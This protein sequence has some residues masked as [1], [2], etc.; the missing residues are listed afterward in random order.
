MKDRTEKD[1]SSSEEGDDDE[2]DEDEARDVVSAVHETSSGGSDEDQ[3]VEAEPD[4]ED[5]ECEGRAA[6]LGVG[7]HDLQPQASDDVA[8]DEEVCEEVAEAEDGGEQRDHKKDDDDDDAVFATFVTACSLDQDDDESVAASG[9]GETSTWS[10]FVAVCEGSDV[11]SDITSQDEDVSEH[12]GPA[13]DSLAAAA[14]PVCSVVDSASDSCPDSPQHDPTVTHITLFSVPD[15]LPPGDSAPPCAA[16]R[17]G[18]PKSA[19]RRRQP[20]AAPTSPSASSTE[21]E[22]NAP[23]SSSE[24]ETANEASRGVSVVPEAAPTPA[25]P[26]APTPAPRRAATTLPRVVA[27]RPATILQW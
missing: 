8:P 13:A 19:S 22:S 21:C 2:E 24:D 11:S 6:E 7:D 18:R 17:P 12:H 15:D 25:P 5:R 9:G 14:S 23:G 4:K 20:A 1:G 10:P 16:P 3:P 27:A 26:A